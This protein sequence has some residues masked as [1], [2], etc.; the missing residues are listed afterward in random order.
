M[1]HSNINSVLYNHLYTQASSFNLDGDR[2]IAVYC[3]LK[4]A[5]GK[6]KESIKA[7]KTKGLNLISKLT[8]ISRQTLSK[9]ITVL[10]TLDL[11]HFSK[12]GSL[13][14][15]GNKKLEERFKTKSRNYRVKYFKINIG[16]TIAETALNSYNIRL[17]GYIDSIN[18][19][20]D[21]NGTSTKLTCKTYDKVTLS[22]LGFGLLKSAGSKPLRS[23]T[24]QKNKL[25]KGN[26]WKQKL[27]KAN[28]I[29]TSRQYEF[30]KH[31]S[32]EDYNSIRYNTFDRTLRWEKGKMYKELCS[33][34]SVEPIEKISAVI[35][36]TKTDYKKKD[37]LQFDMI[38]FW[39]NL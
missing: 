12:N 29:Y 17:H 4:S 7:G 9:Y 34:I 33:L 11:V 18:R 5:R 37:Y 35:K 15:A 13:I 36:E 26:Y 23:T 27:I 2:L 38:D 30:I 8:G 22:V 14:F 1:P 28:C 6:N 24:A 10:T 21:K 20:I 25:S 16:K 39:K 19:R 31:C 32:K 3:I